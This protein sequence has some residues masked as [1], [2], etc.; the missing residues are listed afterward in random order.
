MPR[1]SV[2][3]FREEIPVT[4]IPGGDN[5]VW[6]IKASKR[7]AMR[8]L[9]L[10]P[11]DVEKMQPRNPQMNGTEPANHKPAKDKAGLKRPS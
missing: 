5:G 9:G 10:S 7:D 6:I 4:F 2:K 1:N 11:A 3:R 8:I